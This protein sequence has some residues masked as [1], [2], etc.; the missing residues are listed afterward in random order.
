[1]AL[2]IILILILITL[3]NGIIIFNRTPIPNC[4]DEQ[5][6]SYINVVSPSYGKVIDIISKDTIT[7]KIL[8]T[9]FDVHAQ[10][11][12]ISGILTN[13]EHMYGT[14]N[15]VFNNT[16]LTGK[17]LENEHIKYQIT[18]NI[19][20]SLTATIY[21]IAGMFARRCVSFYSKGSFLE[22]Q[23]PLGRILFGS[24]VDIIIPKCEIMC[25]IGDKL[26]GGETII[27]KYPKPY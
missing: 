12:P 6:E 26:I 24:Q 5:N 18:S 3:I 20:N 25:K 23:K 11:I 19:D 9:I 27:A 2:L 8:L 10:Y 14:H 1:M 22:Y 13:I 4:I 21:Q 17:T 16:V 7:F 15:P